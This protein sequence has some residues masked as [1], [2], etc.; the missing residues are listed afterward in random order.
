MDISYR[1]GLIPAF[2][3]LVIA[4]ALPATAAEVSAAVAANFTRP[5]EEL[6]AA[7][8]ARSG[9]DVVLSFG[10]T[11][12][13]YAQISQ[14]APFAV[15]LAADGERPSQAVAD[16]LGVEGTVFT[17]AV[18]KVVLYSP[19]LDL[20]DGVA[21]LAATEFRHIAMADPATAPYGA[22]G[23]EVI[24][25]LGL[26]DTLA[27]RM[28]TSQSIT[29]ALQ[30]VESG[31]AELGFVALSQVLDKLAGQVWLVPDEYYTPIRQ[32]AV[33]LKE[34]ET[35]DAAKAFLEFLKTDDAEAILERFGYGTGGDALPSLLR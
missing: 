8:K 3:M 7:F 25:K 18:G 2:A 30:F 13:L 24:E 1:V 6:A 23:A 19:S 9:H 5:A 35:A 27:S 22:A 4:V 21:V 17:Y 10:A 16:G 32:D 15:F 29:Q 11:G 31:N 20:S 28:V 26:T 12:A 33:L 14:G 34:G